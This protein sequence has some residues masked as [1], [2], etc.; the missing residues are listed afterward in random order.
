MSEIVWHRS[1]EFDAER[2]ADHVAGYL[3][4]VGDKT[5]AVPG[6]STPFP[7]FDLLAERDIAWDSVTIVL[8]DDRIVPED[9]PASNLGRLRQAFAQT[10]AKIIGLE[11]GARA[12]H[13]DLL[14]LGMGADGHIASL[15]PSTD[16]SLDAP[17]T[18]IRLTPDPL[19]PEAPFDRLSWTLPA[20]LDNTAAMLTIKGAD[21]L[22]IIEA[23]ATGEHDL[24]IARYIAASTSPLHIFGS[25]T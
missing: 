2:I 21:K 17:K 5:I 18:A 4:G 9:H 12:P 19:P 14:W 8:T 10:G 20:L 22:A 11:D 1:A 3:S 23:A 6:G 7:V 24:P 15:F 13:F 16:P 25:E